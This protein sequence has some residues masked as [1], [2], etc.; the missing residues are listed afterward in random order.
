MKKP[1][2]EETKIF[3]VHLSKD[4][5]FTIANDIYNSLNESCPGCCMSVM[6]VLLSML[7]IKYIRDDEGKKKIFPHEEW[8]KD[9]S[10]SS[11]QTVNRYERVGNSVN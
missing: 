3:R 1:K 7:A 8:I 6:T 4:E 5:T 11:L 10:T 9:I 2:R